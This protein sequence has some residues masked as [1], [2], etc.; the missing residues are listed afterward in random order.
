MGCAVYFCKG[1]ANVLLALFADRQ[2]VKGNETTFWTTHIFRLVEI[3]VR[4]LI[5]M[6]QGLTTSVSDIISQEIRE[7]QGVGEN[8]FI[9]KAAIGGK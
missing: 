1:V 4:P 5:Y 9:E 7:N 3:K 6:G 8:Y 2:I